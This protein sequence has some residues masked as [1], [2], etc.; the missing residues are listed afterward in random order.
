[1]TDGL[2]ARS[3]D[4]T[5]EP[6]QPSGPNALCAQPQDL[7]NAAIAAFDLYVGYTFQTSQDRVQ[8]AEPQ[9]DAFFAPDPSVVSAQIAHNPFSFLI[10]FATGALEYPSYMRVDIISV[11]GVAISKCSLLLTCFLT[12]V[13]LIKACAFSVHLM[14]CISCD[15]QACA[16]TCQGVLSSSQATHL[17]WCR[18]SHFPG[19]GVSLHLLSRYGQLTHLAAHHN[20]QRYTSTIDARVWLRQL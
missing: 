4:A 1:M 12:V 14:I 3:Q 17:L 15:R 13:F 20:L 10:S 7:T 9:F 16:F 5:Q 11:I 8:T 2:M 19:H 6:F 18:A